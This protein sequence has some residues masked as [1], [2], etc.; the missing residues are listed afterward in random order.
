MSGVEALAA[1]R[2][3]LVRT[4]AVLEV[5]LRGLHE[6]WVDADLGPETWSPRIVV[7]HLIEGEMSDWIPRLR[8]LLEFGET[9]PFPVF[10]RFAQ[11][12]RG[13]R[14][15]DD[16][17]DDFAARRSRSLADLDGFRLTGADLDRRGQHPEFGS[18]RLSE[19]LA[20][21]TAHDLGH[22]AQI[23]RTMAGRLREAAGPWKAYIRVLREST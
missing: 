5:W 15:L 10:D 3:I 4:P 12:S 16:L 9:R 6:N 11:L 23:A 7:G 22:L 13:P 2:E 18:V 20:A 17:L 8:H 14:S 21:W 1:W 19:H